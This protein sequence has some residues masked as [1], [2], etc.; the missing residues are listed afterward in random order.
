[1]LGQKKEK[2]YLETLVTKTEIIELEESSIDCDE[3][4]VLMT[5]SPNPKDLPDASFIIQHQFCAPY[6]KEYL[7]GCRCGIFCVESTEKGNPH[8]HGWYQHTDDY[9]LEQYRIQWMKVLDKRGNVKT[10]EVSHKSSIRIFQWYS[11]GNCLY[12]YKKD[13]PGVGIHIPFNPI[14]K[15]TDIPEIDVPGYWFSNEGRKT[16]KAVIEKQSTYKQLCE[17]YGKVIV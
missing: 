17:F 12:Y 7:K 9:E 16:S 6:I 1:M 8:Y 13:I 4:L 2:F 14:T 15:T 10:T 3:K 5:W 11:K